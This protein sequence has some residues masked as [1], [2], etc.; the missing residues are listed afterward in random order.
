MM[1]TGLIAV[2]TL[3]Y[4]LIIKLQVRSGIVLFFRTCSKT[5]DGHLYP[6]IIFGLAIYDPTQG[7]SLLYA[8]IVAFLFE[9]PAF[10]VLKNLIKR[11][12]PFVQ[13]DQSCQ[14]IKPSDRFSLPSGHSAAAFVMATLLAFYYPV[15]SGLF[16]GWAFLVGLSRVVLGVHYPFD[17]L[18]GAILGASSTLLGITLTQSIAQ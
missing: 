11:D 16:F 6:I 18:M 4:L 9:V 5:G 10:I 2:D 13:H 12:R 1:R 15:W 14:L 7:F 3:F 8:A 17:I